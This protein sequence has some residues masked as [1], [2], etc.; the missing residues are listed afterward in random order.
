MLLFL[1]NPSLLACTI[2]HVIQAVTH[3]SG[4]T[5]LVAGDSK[6]AQEHW[7]KYVQGRIIPVHFRVCVCVGKKNEVS[8]VRRTLRTHLPST[9]HHLCH[10]LIYT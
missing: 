1:P 8:D 9:A 5:D 10:S 7:F 4:M 2:G 6:R 3:D